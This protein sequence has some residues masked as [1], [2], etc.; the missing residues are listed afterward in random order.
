VKRLLLALLPF[1]T[2]AA[3]PVA[4]WSPN[5]TT[6][7]VWATNIT[8]GEAVW[9]RIGTLQV[10]MDVLSSSQR[11]LTKSDTLHGTLHLA[12][13]WTP[14]FSGLNRGIGGLRGD[15]QH[16]FG[17]TELAPTFTVEAAGDGVFTS[18]QARRGAQTALTLKLAKAFAHG[19]HIAAAEKFDRYDAKRTVFDSSAAETSVEVSHDLNEETRFALTGR[20]RDGDVVTYAE[21]ERPDLAAIAHDQTAVN[22]FHRDMTA[23]AIDGKT[24]A[25]RA[26][27]IHATSEVS[28]MVLWYEYAVTK[29]T[30][31]QYENQTVGLSF[32]RQ[33]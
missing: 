26:A 2:F 25:V 6:S 18:E 17:S 23:Y 13:D 1:T 5:V 28:A 21:F 29:H 20:W 14:R 31:L 32:V 22:T 33:F 15:W 30:G 11:V 12:G 10:G 4:D 9:D 19:W 27:L 24:T 3:A 16:T 7:F 8:N